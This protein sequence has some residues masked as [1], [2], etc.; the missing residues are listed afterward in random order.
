MKHIGVPRHEQ[1]LEPG[2]AGPGTIYDADAVHSRHGVINQ[3]EVYRPLSFEDLEGVGRIVRF[4]D[5]MTGVPQNW[6]RQGSARPRRRRRPGGAPAGPGAPAPEP[7]PRR[8][9]DDLAFGARQPQVHCRALSRGT[10]DLHRSSG[11]GGKAMYDR[12]PQAGAAARLFRGKER[13]EGPSSNLR[14]HPGAGV[15]D[16]DHHIICPAEGRPAAMAAFFPRFSHR[17]AGCPRWAWH[18][19]HSGPGS[20]SRARAGSGPPMRG[21]PCSEPI[22]SRISGPIVCLRIF[23]APSIAALMSTGRGSRCWRRQRRADAG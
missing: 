15:G 1:H 18:P 2:L 8:R 17:S 4:P 6:R 12:Q 23:S 9:L 14:T 20:G 22:T 3:Q 10:D 16:R 5:R 7:A 13:L 11:L 21:M 19:V